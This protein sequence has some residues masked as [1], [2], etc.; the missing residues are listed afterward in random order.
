MKL[1]ISL[2]AVG[3]LPTFTFG[4]E[5]PAGP[6]GTPGAQGAWGRKGRPDPGRGGREGRE[7]CAR[8]EGRPRGRDEDRHRHEP[9]V[10]GHLHDDDGR[11]DVDLRLYVSADD[12]DVGRRHRQREPS[13]HRVRELQR[14]RHLLIGRAGT[15]GATSRN[16]DPPLDIVG[17]ENK[18]Y[19]TISTAAARPRSS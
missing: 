7:R 2:L 12:P 16:V 13:R 18:G 4:C 1:S 19:E 8:R 10:H 9:S 14:V 5:G 15:N 11:R 3:A 17:T 6:T